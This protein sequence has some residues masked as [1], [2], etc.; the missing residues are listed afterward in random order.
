MMS[1]LIENLLHIQRR[2]RTEHGLGIDAVLL[3]AELFAEGGGLHP[4]SHEGLLLV[5][6]VG[7]RV[8]VAVGGDFR[9]VDGVGVDV[10]GG[11]LGGVGDGL[12]GGER[13]LVGGVGGVGVFGEGDLA[14]GVFGHVHGVCWP[15]RLAVMLLL[16]LLLLLM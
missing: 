1:T 5:V 7:V 14:V 10:V 12:F 16:L 15:W 2:D 9:Q 6:G 13:R 4:G 11:G 8:G 3:R